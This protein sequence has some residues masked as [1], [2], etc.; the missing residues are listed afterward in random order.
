[1]SDQ[2]MNF[3]LLPPWYRA[4]IIHSFKI[5]F[6][7]TKTLFNAQT[8]MRFTMLFSQIGKNNVIPC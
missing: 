7:I 2:G 5:Y 4:P 3:N 6:F 1:M 8:Q